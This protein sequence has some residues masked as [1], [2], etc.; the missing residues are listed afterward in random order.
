M[1]SRGSAATPSHSARARAGIRRREV[2]VNDAPLA[3]LLAQNNPKKFELTRLLRPEKYADTARIARLQPYDPNKFVV[4]VV[5]GLMDTPATWT[6]MLCF[7][8]ASAQAV[9]AAIIPRA[10]GFSA[11]QTASMPAASAARACSTQACGVMP[12]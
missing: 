6:P 1:P 10:N 9:A 3:V 7:L 2:G 5:H 11:N 12:P 8:V 4:L